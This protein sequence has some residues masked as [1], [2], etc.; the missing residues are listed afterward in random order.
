MA[1][2]TRP[3]L[4]DFLAAPDAVVAAVAPVTAA[5]A[6]S[7]SR[8]QATIEGVPIDE[9]YMEWS[10]PQ[11]VENLALFFRLG[12]RHLIVPV[13]GPNQ[14]IEGG[15]YGEQ[16]IDWCIRGL[17]G[18]E[19][20][21]EYQRR[22]WRARFIVPSPVATLRA[23]AAQLQQE[24]GVGRG[25]TV[26]YYV[27]A[28]GGDPWQDLLDTIQRTG[29]RTYSEVLQA[30]CGEELPPA[31]LLVGFGKPLTGTNLLPPLL[32]GPTM[33]GYWTQRAG[34]RL[35][36]PMLRRILYDYA[37]N[38]PTFH[39]DR[40]SRYDEARQQP[41]LWDTTAIL[42]VGTRIGSYWYPEPFSGASEPG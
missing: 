16:I 5:Y 25:P 28:Q 40:G 12:V 37:Y 26:W 42:G 3:T 41:A 7:G 15:L 6:P 11:M 10:R 13:L 20:V 21:H 19:M 1:E 22:G 33:H 30:V 4:E 23:A 27:V 32:T 38:R 18:P 31:T 29:A 35:T 17:A 34:L 9:R 8:R 14:F 24:T 39:R 2:E 36:E